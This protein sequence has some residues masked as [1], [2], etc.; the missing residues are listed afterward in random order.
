MKNSAVNLDEISTKNHL[1]ILNKTFIRINNTTLGR[2]LSLTRKQQKI[3]PIE[4]FYGHLKELSENCD[5]GEKGDT[6]T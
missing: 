6:I 1:D 2:Y 5:L 4:K 3:E